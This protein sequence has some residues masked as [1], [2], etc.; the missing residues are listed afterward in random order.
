MEEAISNPKKK[1]KVVDFKLCFIC[2]CNFENTDYSSYVAKPSL[3]S[4]EKIIN[5]AKL[6]CSYG[7]PE[8][9]PLNDQCLEF[10]AEDLLTK[11]ISYHRQCYSNLTYKTKIESAKARF[12]KGVASGDVTIITKKPIGRPSLSVLNADSC[13]STSRRISRDRLFDK[14][15]C[16]LCQEETV[17][18]LHEV[19]TKAMGTHLMVIGQKTRNETLKVRLSSIVTSLDPLTA[20]AEDM[21]YHLACFVRIKRET[22]SA[23]KSQLEPVDTINQLLSDLDIIDMVLN[24]LNNPEETPSVLN[25]NDIQDAYVQLLNKN[26]IPVPDNPRYKPYLKQLILDNIPDVHFSRSPDR[27]KPEQ[28]M[29]TRQADML[30]ASALSVDD[31]RGDLQILLKAAKIL[32]KDITESEP[33]KFQGSFKDFKP[34]VMLDAFCKHVV[35]GTHR[36]KTIIREE[37]ANQSASILAQHFIQ[38]FKSDRQ[39]SYKPTNANSTFRHNFETPISVGLA[40]DVHKSTRSSILVDK[41]EKLDLAITYDKVM[42]IETGIANRVL[43]QMES[44]GGIYLPH[45]VEKNEFVWFAMDNIDFLEA[46]PSGMNTLHGTAIAMYQTDAPGKSLF[47]SPVEI[48]RSPGTTSLDHVIESKILSCPKPNP[49][50][51]KHECYLATLKPNIEKNRNIDIS[52]IIGC[53]TFDEDGV[54]I[55]KKAPGTWGA[56]NSLMSTS[57]SVHSL[58]N[59]ALVPPLIRSPPTDYNTLYTG[60]MRAQNITTCVMGSNSITVVTLDLQ[61]Y[62]MAM[63]LWV[64]REDIRK[65]F[66]FRPGELHVVFWALASLGDYIEGS[67]I[68]QAWVEAGLYSPTT[69]N[70]ILNGKQLYRSLEAYTITLIVLYK[71]YFTK[72]LKTDADDIAFFEKLSN[73]LTEAFENDTTSNTERHDHLN[74][75]V[76][77]T[78]HMFKSRNLFE[79]LEIFEKGAN[80]LQKFILNYMKQFGT[81]LQFVRSTRQRD[82]HLHME[83]IESLTK[84]FFVHDHLNYARLLPLYISTMQHTEKEHPEIWNEFLKGNFCIT[85]GLSGFTSIAPDHGIEH[86]NRT[87]KVMGGIVGITQNENALDKF[88]LIAPELSKLLHEFQTEYSFR[89]TE[90]RSEHH[91]ITGG[92]LARILRNSTKLNEVILNHGNPFSEDGNDM[93]NLLTKQVMNENVCKDLVNR[94]NIGQIMFQDFVKER[95]QTGTLSVWDP[96]KK[97]KLNTFRSSNVTTEVKINEKLVKIKEERGLLQ[98]FIVI[99]RSRPEL[100]L[101]ECIAT[102]EFGIIPRSLFASDGSLLLAK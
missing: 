15:K 70:K 42:E 100:D 73:G 87:L 12:E 79:K 47:N 35:Q 46:T 91:E 43:M 11:G 44:M 19:T 40:L 85:K 10:S 94:D 39:I 66:L 38:A 20:V 55:N 33:W 25:M 58:T 16:I 51:L 6:R 27:T 14:N 28:V 69:V 2:Q 1:S 36:V 92:K 49:K 82:I 88:F 101:K 18:D 34:P 74:A 57:Q 96:M 64:E 31:V 98:R 65:K 93:Y 24:D 8:Y 48:N 75:T 5:T 61:L 72:F 26:E 4:I 9:G 59:I 89:C 78:I 84:Y 45:W 13:A 63:K 53:L 54:G 17:E 21:K 56:F 83:S 95:I 22:E 52:W 77:E 37:S 102:Y 67:G 80:N 90:K 81:I 32:R 86:E 68:D 50:K 30:I 71:L 97:R 62:D 60:L 41:L 3:V 99:S 76:T 29:L 23:E 7:E